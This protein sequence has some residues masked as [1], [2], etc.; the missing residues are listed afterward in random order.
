M[1]SSRKMHAKEKVEINDPDDL[2]VSEV[3]CINSKNLKKSSF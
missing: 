2:V 1:Y 3:H